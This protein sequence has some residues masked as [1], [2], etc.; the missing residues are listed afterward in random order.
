MPGE[1]ILKDF[2]VPQRSIDFQVLQSSGMPL[3]EKVGWGMILFVFW[4]NYS[5]VSA[6]IDQR[7]ERLFRWKFQ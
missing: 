3:R 6:E 2:Q 5:G 1:Q 4:T 7:A